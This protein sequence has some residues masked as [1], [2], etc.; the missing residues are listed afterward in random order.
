MRV[1]VLIGLPGSGKSTW[2]ATQGAA[3]LSSDAIRV[4]LVDDATIQTIHSRVFETLR[5]LL[6]QRLALG[7]PLTF[8]DA[9]NLRPD[10]RRPYIAIARAFGARPEA[11]FFD[12]P[13]EICR[14][15][16][17]RR[18]R[19]VPE[20]AMELMASRLVPPTLEEGFERIEVITA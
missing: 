8:I 10:E 19:I 13:L 6:H 5:Y 1:V 12:I 2:A 9:T 4:L 11:A 16:N 14:E 15:R 20:D 3:A 18:H 7:R 17:A